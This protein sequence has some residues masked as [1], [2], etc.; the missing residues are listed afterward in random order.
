[1][2]L[3]KGIKEL[4]GIEVLRISNQKHGFPEH[5][6]DTFCISLIENG[7]EAI[8]MGQHTLFTEQGGISITNA[9]EIH[10]NPIVDKE[11]PNSFTTLYLSPDIVDFFIGEKGVTFSHQQ[12]Y[13]WK[14]I[15]L[16]R[17]IVAALAKPNIKELSTPLNLLL[18]NFERTSTSALNELK[19]SDRQW[20]ELML[21][22]DNKLEEK[23]TLD[24]LAKFM[25]MDKFNFAK[26][27]RAKYGL[28]P[29]N[30]VIM[31]K[32]F[33]AKQLIY[34]NTNLTQLAY[35]FNFSDQA[36]FS[37]QFKRF[38]GVSPK[39]YKNQLL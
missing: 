25:N 24:L 19:Q 28:S 11:S 7:I 6:H 2:K 30:Y 3:K 16:F 10:A 23:V 31:K 27:F 33:K 26:A 9:Y 14:N 34:Q 39:A 36:H 4:D 21:L 29:I 32:I 18:S 15:N 37:K 17:Q 12:Q 38:I 35:Q 8:K 20:T 5:Y 22:I 13:S 1:M